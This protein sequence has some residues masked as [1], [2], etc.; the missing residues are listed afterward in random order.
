MTFTTFLRFLMA[1]IMSPYYLFNCVFN[2]YVYPAVSRSDAYLFCYFVGN[3]VEEQTI[4]FAVSTDGYN[5]KALN[6]NEAVIEQTKGTGCVR[7]PYI[8]KGVD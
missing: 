1:I 7:D 8:L 4:H 5:Y 3:E 6:G 2:E